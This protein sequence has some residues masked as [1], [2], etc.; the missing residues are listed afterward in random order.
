MEAI[1]GTSLGVFITVTL[2]IIGGASYMTGQAVASTWRPVGQV[3]FYV[4][5]LGLTDRFLTF[6]LFEG[7]LLSPTGFLVDT[8]V[9]A[10]I[11][12]FAYRITRVSK[13]VSQYP[14]LYE[15]SGPWS[16]REKRSPD[17]GSAPDL[18]Q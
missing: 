12:L 18:G 14:W 10:A 17:A 1:L 5:L 6:A 7:D 16:Y 4:V 3:L 15:R 2:V 9:I 11:G 8:A 13:M